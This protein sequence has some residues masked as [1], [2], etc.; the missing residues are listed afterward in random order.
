VYLRR[1]VSNNN[2]VSRKVP[3]RFAERQK[4]NVGKS[5]QNPHDNDLTIIYLFIYERVEKNPLEVSQKWSF[6]VARIDKRLKHVQRF[7]EIM[8]IINT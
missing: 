5:E 6:L 3:G 8:T 1:E 2:R 4:H 7:V